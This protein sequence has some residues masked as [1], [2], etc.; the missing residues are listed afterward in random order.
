MTTSSLDRLKSKLQEKSEFTVRIRRN[1]LLRI[2]IPD[3]DVSASNLQLTRLEVTPQLPAHLH[4]M[5]NIYGDPTFFID[6]VHASKIN[7]LYPPFGNVDFEC[8][9]LLLTPTNDY[10][11]SPHLKGFY[12][13]DLSPFEKDVKK[14]EIFEDIEN[15]RAIVVSRVPLDRAKKMMSKNWEIIYYCDPLLRTSIADAVIL[16]KRPIVDTKCSLCL[17]DFEEDGYRLKRP[18]CNAGIYHQKC[19]KTFMESDAIKRCPMCRMGLEEFEL[20]DIKTVN[21]W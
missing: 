5:L 12:K 8:N 20:C 14:A 2:Y 13:K 18:C 10:I 16:T 17:E 1:G 11:I 19:W 15:K 3:I 9:S 4:K 6:V 7:G 21:L